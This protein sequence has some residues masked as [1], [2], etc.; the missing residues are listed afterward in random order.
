MDRI[1]TKIAAVL[2]VTI[3]VMAIF[4]G[5]QVLLLGKDPGYFVINWLPVYNFVLGFVAVFVGVG[6]IWR[7]SRYALPAALAILGAHT[8]VMVLLQTS[9]QGI[10]SRDSIVAMTVRM[11]V[12]LVIV[13]LLLVQRRKDNRLPSA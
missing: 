8:L 2:A 6:L 9:Y 1:Y 12:W 5:G 4:A 3:G 11:V 7:G 10:V 13:G